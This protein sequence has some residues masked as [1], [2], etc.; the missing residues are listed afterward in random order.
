MSDRGY[1]RSAGV[2]PEAA[3]QAAETESQLWLRLS[4]SE[5]FNGFANAWLALQ[6]G[7]IERA[8]C[9]IVLGTDTQQSKVE[10]AAAWPE[11]YSQPKALLDLASRALKDQRLVASGDDGNSYGDTATYVAMPILV[12]RQLVG[13]V[14]IGM[15]NTRGED[16]R[17]A[18]RQLQWGS[19]WFRERTWRLLGEDS[20]R[21]L[22]RSRT[23]LDLL[24]DALSRPSYDAA[25]MAVA[26]SLA[27]K[28]RASRVSFGVRRGRFTQVRVISH[29]AQFN[30][31]LTIVSHLAAA[32]D[33]AVDQQ[34]LVLYPE[35]IHQIAATSE[36]QTLSRA[37]DDAIILTIPTLVADR[38]TGAACFERPRDD[39][40]DSETIELLETSMAIIGPVLE[41]KRLNDRWLG[42][43]IW[44]SFARQVRLVFGPGNWG[45]K[46]GILATLA[47]AAFLT[48]ATGEFRIDADALV[49]GLARRALVAPYDGYIKDAQHRAGDAVKKGDSLAA[50]E[51]S[52]LV[53]E[54]LK[55]VTERDQ[56]V[57]EYDKALAGRD[58]AAVNVI[59]TQIKQAEAQIRLVD[60]Q[61]A[62]VNLRAPID[63]LIISGD[64][65]QLIG[66]AV[67]RGQVLFEIAPLDA[68]RVI[69]LVDEHDVGMIEADQRGELAVTALPDQRL[70]FIVEKVTP[71]AEAKAGKNIF[72]V[73]GRIDGDT[74]RLRPGMEGLGKV[75][76]GTRNLA[77][78]WMRPALNWARFS[79]WRWLG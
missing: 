71:I 38:F 7:A 16:L 45:R 75:S 23:A 37:Q 74:A 22:E 72:R 54:R 59:S 19:N 13:V 76:I 28:V 40:F 66:T 41:E 32:M 78:I 5:T 35:P 65:T 44:E 10:V 68:Y 70:S 18:M 51:D 56:R 53:L 49:E 20:V 47:I 14:A 11:G 62:R 29:S 9:G 24:A 64:L 63:G 8:F 67:Q 27:A 43:K 42:A 6:C 39:P 12:R 17:R 36:H 31:R 21:A 60:E 33:E 61:M 4:N 3:Q 50:L 30:R 55:H 2:P 46:F 52:D 48:F 73:E 26:S 34:S 15:R 57:H 1:A 79:I 69:L 77:W 58:L 25:A